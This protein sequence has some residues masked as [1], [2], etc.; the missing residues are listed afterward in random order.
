MDDTDRHNETDPSGAGLEAEL[1]AENAEQDPADGETGQN[2]E[3]A[4]DTGNGESEQ[5]VTQQMDEIVEDAAAVA[6]AEARDGAVGE[7]R[8]EAVGDMEEELL[9]LDPEHPLMKGFQASLK[10]HLE[11]QLERLE[12]ELRELRSMERAEGDGCVELGSALYKVQEEL[13]RVDTRLKG[14]NKANT[15][16][17]SQRQKAQERLDSVRRQYRTSVARNNQQRTQVSQIQ[18]EVDDM[19][20]RL[21]YLHGASEDMCS[22][23]ATTQTCTRKAQVEKNHAAQQKNMQDL[24]VD[25]L[26]QKLQRLME[27]AA[28][29]EAQATAQAMEAQVAQE[30]L[31]EAQMELDALLVEQKQLLQQWNSSLL[32]VRRRDEAYNTMQE[33]LRAAR[34]Q[35][36]ALDTEIEGFRKSIGQEEERNEQLTVA[37]NSAR[38]DCGTS[39]KLIARN[40]AQ[41]EALLGQHA[42]YARTLQETERMLEEVTADCAVRRGEAA[43][44]RAQM[45]REA[46]V[47]RDL[48]ERIMGKMQEQLSHGQ[49]AKCSRQQVEKIAAQKKERELQVAC[50]RTASLR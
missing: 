50:W 21:L 18:A 41:E 2:G 42:T 6:V 1:P 8:D 46:G 48:E 17:S 40:K 47:R 43:A 9:V 4:E 39:R 36:R 22:D 35:A 14:Q 28:L 33:A 13:G 49:A 16:A 38:L 37:L 12:N 30:G 7:R 27:E 20:L 32:G 24:Y 44:L 5:G 31:S 25:R 19:A 3:A 45:D 15:S 29:Y 23:L 26:S 34:D 10:T 11:K